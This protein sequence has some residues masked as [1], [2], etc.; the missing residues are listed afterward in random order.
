MIKV[1]F[2][3]SK[4]DTLEDIR[5]KKILDNFTEGDFFRLVQGNIGS[6]RKEAPFRDGDSLKFISEV[7]R[8]EFVG[9]EDWY[10]VVTPYGR[11][12]VTA[13]C[14]GTQFALVMIENSRNGFYTA[15]DGQGYGEDIWGRLADLSIDVL[16]AFDLSRLDPSFASLPIEADYEVENFPY[17][18]TEV[19]AVISHNNLDRG[20]MKDGIYYSGYYFSELAYRWYNDVGGIIGR[21]EE[22]VK[23]AGEHFY[24]PPAVFTLKNFAKYLSPYMAMDFNPEYLGQMGEAGEGRESLFCENDLV[25][26]NYLQNIPTE[27]MVKYP[28]NLVVTKCTDGDCIIRSICSVKYPTYSEAVM[29]NGVLSFEPR[30]DEQ[31]VLVL[32]AEV[33]WEGCDA[34]EQVQWGF[35]NYGCILELYDGI[36]ALEEFVKEIKEAFEAGKLYVE[37][38]EW[39]NAEQIKV[40]KKAGKD[41]N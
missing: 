35:R 33:L 21:A 27:P 13:L 25:I 1:K 12:N 19:R 8:A 5:E 16:A 11:T 18:G 14:S 32:D 17:G 15:V 2:Y 9:G 29:E 41:G 30:E 3:N 26:R 38:E 34:L 36:R 20:Y 28:I 7:D 37:Y 40:R 39:K 4:K 22:L 6:E 23:K 10:S 24:Y 31:Y